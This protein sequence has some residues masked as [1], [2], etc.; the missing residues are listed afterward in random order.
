MRFNQYIIEAVAQNYFQQFANAKNPKALYRTLA[1]KMHTD[2]GGDKEEFQAMQAAWDEF[3]KKGSGNSADGGYNAANAYGYSYNYPQRQKGTRFQWS[4]GICEVE[5]LMGGSV[6]VVTELPDNPG[7]SVTNGWPKIANEI[8]QEF[9]I[10]PSENIRW[11]ERYTQE[12]GSNGVKET[13]EQVTMSIRDNEYQ[14]DPRWTRL[15]DKD[16]EQFKQ[17]TMANAT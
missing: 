12:F 17:A 1:I 11:I 14:N 4:R 7:Q 5:I 10:T 9:G 15:N 16:V 2:N 6:I 3:E 13:Y 8:C